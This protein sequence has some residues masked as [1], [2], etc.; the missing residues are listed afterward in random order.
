ML[1]RSLCFNELH[2]ILNIIKFE[3]INLAYCEMRH[4]VTKGQDQYLHIRKRTV[5]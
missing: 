3:T 4:L 1:F 2:L 5:S